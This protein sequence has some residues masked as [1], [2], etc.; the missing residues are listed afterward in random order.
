MHHNLDQKAFIRWLKAQGADVLTPTSQY[1]FARFRAHGELHIIW[2]NKREQISSLEFGQ[3]CLEHF[4]RG[5]GLKMGFS[6]G[7]KTIPQK[8]KVQL[9]NRDGADCFFCQ[10]P[11]GDDVTIEHLVAVARGG[12][13]HT[14]NL[15]LAHDVCNRSAGNMSLME[16]INIHT[17][18]KAAQQKDNP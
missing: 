13:D 1:E 8:I 18:A 10:R 11:L 17:A 16:K 15:A 4:T 2:R 3:K 6:T 9:M 12:P 7:R 5:A 14:D